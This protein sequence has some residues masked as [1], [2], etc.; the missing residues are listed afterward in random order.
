M[1]GQRMLHR[2]MIGLRNVVRVADADRLVVRQLPKLGLAAVRFKHQGTGD[3]VAQF[4]GVAGEDEFDGEESTH[5]R[6]R[7]RSGSFPR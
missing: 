6:K 5:D 4:V 3:G 2:K 1:A 7:T